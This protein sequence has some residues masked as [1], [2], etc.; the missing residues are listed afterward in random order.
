MRA[1]ERRSER[2]ELALVGLVV[3]FQVEAVERTATVVTKS[4]PLTSAQ[5]LAN[6][7][8]GRATMFERVGILQ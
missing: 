2:H 6:S 4:T 5:A 3:E 1:T 7:L 8:L